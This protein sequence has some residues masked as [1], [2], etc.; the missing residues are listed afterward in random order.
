MDD[1]GD[2]EFPPQKRNQDNLNGKIMLSAIVSLSVVVVLVTVLHIY[3]RFVLRRRARRR[4]AMREIRL[5]VSESYA[6]A[7]AA[8]EQPKTGLDPS[9]IA[10]LPLFVFKQLSDD[11]TSAECAVCLSLLEEDHDMARLLPNC[12]HTFHAECIDKWLR[13]QSTCPICRTE[14]EPPSREAVADGGALPTAPPVPEGVMNST[15][16]G[17]SSR[18]SSFGRMLSRERSSR[19]IQSCGEEDGQEDIERQ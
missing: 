3:A 1:H 19:R 16:G 17:I 6:A 15:R 12:K 10:S 11:D 8:H 18:L 2:D 5:A 4:A 13:S 7:T 9:V 14:A